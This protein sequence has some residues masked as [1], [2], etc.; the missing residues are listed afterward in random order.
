[1]ETLLSYQKTVIFAFGAQT[2][3]NVCIALIAERANFALIACFAKNAN[4]AMNASIALIATTATF[5][6]IA[7]TVRIATFVIPALALTTASAALIQRKKSTIFLT[8]NTQKTIILKNF[9]KL[10]SGV[11]KKNGINSRKSYKLNQKF[12]CIK[13]TTKNVL[14]II[15][16]TAKTA[17]GVLIAI[18]VKIAPIFLMQIWKGVVKTAWIAAQ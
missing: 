14:E 9:P 7:K 3:K 2:W 13:W 4:F 8:K 6:R 1:M 17:I 16:I 10:K 11:L 5:A 15:Y 12:L 18:Y